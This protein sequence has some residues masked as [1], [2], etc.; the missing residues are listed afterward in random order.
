MW[1]GR[2]GAEALVRS[3]TTVP[4]SHSK[5]NSPRLM[6]AQ[7]LAVFDP[8]LFTPDPTGGQP[9]PH[10]LVE[11][12]PLKRQ[13]HNR[14][15]PPAVCSSSLYGNPPQKKIRL[16]HC[17]PLVWAVLVF[18][19]EGVLLVALPNLNPAHPQVIYAFGNR[20]EER[21][22][23]LAEYKKEAEEYRAAGQKRKLEGEGE[24]AAPQ[25]KGPRKD[26]YLKSYA[27]G[28]FVVSNPY[29]PRLPIAPAQQALPPD[30]KQLALL[31]DAKVDAYVPPTPAEMAAAAAKEAPVA[32]AATKVEQEQE[33]EEEAKEPEYEFAVSSVGAAKAKQAA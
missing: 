20:P 27:D 23:L 13:M 1:E 29:Q 19:W 12:P 33:E 28:E 5:N 25:P 11:D 14:K 24:E 8:S 9:T 16:C 15:Y 26:S 7:Q 17:T 18:F 4:F 10:P 32:P 22:Q 2:Q 21:R 31:R 30:E 6:V 3:G